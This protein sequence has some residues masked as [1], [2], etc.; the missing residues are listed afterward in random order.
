MMSDNHNHY[1]S[2]IPYS[3][4]L[5][6][7]S[8]RSADENVLRPLS[9]NEFGS[10][11]VLAYRAKWLKISAHPKARLICTLTVMGTTFYELGSCDL[12]ERFQYQLPTAFII[13][14]SS[15]LS[16][17]TIQVSSRVNLKVVNASAKYTRRI[18][19]QI[20]GVHPMRA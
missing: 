12:W 8:N 19:A 15:L 18:N 13:S 11:P 5:I 7:Q 1:I 17:A 10:C 16:Y 3:H 20:D 9:T 6:G 4:I 2:L 14:L